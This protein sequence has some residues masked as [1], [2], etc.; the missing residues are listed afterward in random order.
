MIIQGTYTSKILNSK[1]PFVAVLPE[2]INKQTRV[3]FLLHGVATDETEWLINVP[4]EQWAK[5]HNIAFL[6]PNG[7]NTFYTDHADGENYGEAIGD[8]FYHVM[9]ELLPLN[10]D[11]ANTSIAG[12][13]MGGYGAIRLGLK[14]PHYHQIGGFSPAFIFYKRHRDDPLF[15]EVFSKGLEGSDNDCVQLYQN[16]LDGDLPVPTISLYCGD[17]DPLDEQTQN[18]YHQVTAIKGHHPL[19][20][21]QQTGFHDFSLWLPALDQFIHNQVISQS[22]VNTD[23]WQPLQKA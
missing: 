19:A 9:A 6:C 5:S 12:F 20:Y 22:P 14:Y 2:P 21:Y 7:G 11:Y 16:R 18:F 3:V 1:R 10:M 17:Q 23:I 13:S 4:L 8:E 15:K